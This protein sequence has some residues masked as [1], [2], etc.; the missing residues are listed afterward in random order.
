MLRF[1]VR[2]L[3][4]LVPILLGLSILVFLWIRILPGGPAQALLGERGTD[5]QEAQIERQYG[6]DEP[7][8]VQYW[9]YVQTVANGDFGNSITTR[10]P[11]TEELK[12]RFPATI[13]LALAAMFFSIMLGIPLG[14][15]AA[16]KHGSLIDH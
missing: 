5:E 13:E 4:L 12:Q 15:L 2:R 8:H 10:Q 16:K 14:F 11:V 1:V 7:I 6:L 9:K 3:L